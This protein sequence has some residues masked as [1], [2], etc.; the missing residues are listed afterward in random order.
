MAPEPAVGALAQPA[1]SMEIERRNGNVRI[2]LSGELDYDT[3]SALGEELEKLETEQPEVLLIDL[4]VSASW[5]RA[6]SA[7]WR[8]RCAVAGRKDAGWCS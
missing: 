4:R 3:C 8:R 1:F 2:A 7:N 6:A 5:T